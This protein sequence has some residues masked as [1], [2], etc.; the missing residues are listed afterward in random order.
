MMSKLIPLPMPYSSICSPSH[1]KKTV[2]QVIIATAVIC[3]PKESVVVPV[4]KNC[5]LSVLVR[6]AATHCH[7]LEI[8]VALNDADQ[9]GQVPSVFVDLLSSG[10]PSFRS[11]S[12]GFQTVPSN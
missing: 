3:Q 9:N 7:K 2:P 10:L 5:P 6:I 11:C 8:N 1:I 4:A 12:I